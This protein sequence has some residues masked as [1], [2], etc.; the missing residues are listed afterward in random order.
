MLSRMKLSS[1]DF[2]NIYIKIILLRNLMIYSSQSI[3]YF[4]LKSPDY[5]CAYKKGYQGKRVI[6]YLLI[7]NTGGL[8]HE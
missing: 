6:L 3:T 1:I 2:K 5:K 4:Y 8:K 7:R